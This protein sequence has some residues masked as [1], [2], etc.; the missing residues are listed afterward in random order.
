[1]SH[2]WL[3]PHPYAVAHPILGSF[4]SAQGNHNFFGALNM[5]T[6][7]HECYLE[8][9]SSNFIE[10]ITASKKIPPKH[11]WSCIHSLPHT[12]WRS[13][14]IGHPEPDINT[15]LATR[16][17][18]ASPQLWNY[19][20]L[21]HRMWAFLIIKDKPGN[22]WDFMP[23]CT[24]AQCLHLG[25]LRLQRAWNPT[26]C[27]HESLPP[28]SRPQH[29]VGPLNTGFI[30][31]PR[32]YI[33]VLKGKQFSLILRKVMNLCFENCYQNNNEIILL[34]GNWDD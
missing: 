23:N 24:V 19:K 33:P 17:P 16:A 18:V 26:P 32:K 20:L 12:V 28:Q 9:H 2:V 4:W 21:T 8:S 10:R 31:E 3:N 14:L 29:I 15:L 13:T 5:A 27:L 7:W 25:N 34:F 1:M 6:R 22:S 11:E 30:S